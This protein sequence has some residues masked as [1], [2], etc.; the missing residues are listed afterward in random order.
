LP[1]RQ[2]RNLVQSPAKVH[3][4]RLFSAYSISVATS[5]IRSIQILT[6]DRQSSPQ[7]AQDLVFYTPKI[8]VHQL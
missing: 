1:L 6:T 3:R 4:A 8:L 2:S 7:N 5:Y